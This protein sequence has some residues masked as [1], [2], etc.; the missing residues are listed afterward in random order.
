MSSG[1]WAAE[2][3][4]FVQKIRWQ[5][6]SPSSEIVVNRESAGDDCFWGENARRRDHYGPEV[7]K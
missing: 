4:G 6:G 2:N 5:R 3:Y 7:A 1:V